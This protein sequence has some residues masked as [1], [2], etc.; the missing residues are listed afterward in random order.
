[1]K[2]DVATRKSNLA[3]A[4]KGIKASHASGITS[5]KAETARVREKRDILHQNIA[6][7]RR[8]RCKEAADLLGLRRISSKEEVFAIAGVK[9]VDL[10]LIPSTPSRCLTDVD[11]TPMTVMLGISHATHLLTLL[12]DYLSLKLPHEISPPSRGVSHFSIR[13]TPQSKLL[14]LYLP[15]ES[16]SS[17]T[18]RAWGNEKLKDIP[19]LES[20]IEAISLLARAIAWVLWSQQL[21]PPT[22]TDNEAVE[23]SRLGR[24]LVHLVT[25][26]KIGFISHGSA[27]DYLPIQQALGVLPSFTLDSN[28]IQNLIMSALQEDKNGEGD[29]GGWDIV[30]GGEEVLRG[31]GWLKLSSA[32]HSEG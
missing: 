31:D 12:T 14:P 8:S 19:N 23:A 16:F 17:A 24:N 18:A 28:D 7:A 29:G 25:S 13:R 32:G 2:T 6:I 1:V 20:F 22:K 15:P 9:L 30:E 21:W 4:L 11:Y 26:P 3:S 27:I 5:L 10:Y